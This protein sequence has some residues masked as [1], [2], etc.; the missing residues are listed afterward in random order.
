MRAASLT[1][2]ESP[3]RP[4]RYTVRAVCDYFRGSDGV[5]C[6]VESPPVTVTVTAAHVLEW[7]SLQN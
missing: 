5:E 4:G 2:T 6:R 7:K 1:E 3:L